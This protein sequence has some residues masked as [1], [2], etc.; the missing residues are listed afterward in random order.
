ML[1][2]KKGN[3]RILSLCFVIFFKKM[4]IFLNL[5]FICIGSLFL[6]SQ[7]N[8]PI[9]TAIRPPYL[10][11]D[12]GK[13]S[14]KLKG[15]EAASTQ[16]IFMLFHAEQDVIGLDPGLSNDGRWRAIHL[17]EILKNVE[18]EKYFSTPFRN[19]ILT[20]E[21]LT[22][23]RKAELSLYDQADLKSLFKQLD[24]LAP[25]DLVMMIHQQTFAQI[26]RHLISSDY[27]ETFVEQPTDVIYILERKVG[28]PGKLH[29]FKYKIR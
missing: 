2:D 9:L 3:C 5:I 25:D 13:D 26:M 27:T 21:P 20:L 16:L 28:Q 10:I 6:H 15:L 22:N 14:L 23:W 12:D 7:A 1:S 4:R 18:F 8:T 24:L 17:K 11:L 29:K 19:N